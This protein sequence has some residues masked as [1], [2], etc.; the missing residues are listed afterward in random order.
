MKPPARGG[1]MSGGDSAG[2]I[3]QSGDDQ[4]PLKPP[5]RQAGMSFLAAAELCAPTPRRAS[6]PEGKHVLASATGSH[7][8]CA[9]SQLST[10]FVG[11][12]ES[13]CR[14]SGVGV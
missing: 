5:P 7:H 4:S 2:K 12:V 10:T 8:G 1:H 3:D 11:V 14:A 9:A 13:A 6:Q